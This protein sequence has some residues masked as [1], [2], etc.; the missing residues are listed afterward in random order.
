[1]VL[2]PNLLAQTPKILLLEN[3]NDWY[4][5]NIMNEKAYIKKKK[6][7]YKYV[8]LFKRIIYIK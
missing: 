1:M 4:K 3:P 8:N 2:L 5:D 7:I 6:V